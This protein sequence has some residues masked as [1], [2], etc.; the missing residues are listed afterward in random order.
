MGL[1]YPKCKKRPPKLPFFVNQ[2]LIALVRLSGNELAL[3]ASIL[4][5]KN[6]CASLE[7]SKV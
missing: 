2:S 5:T 7:S 6:T 3:F 4:F 1:L